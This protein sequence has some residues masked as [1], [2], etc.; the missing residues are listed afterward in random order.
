MEIAETVLS[1]VKEREKVREEKRLEKLE[2]LFFE[3]LKENFTENL[4]HCVEIPYDN[5]EIRFKNHSKYNRLDLMKICEMNGIKIISSDKFSYNGRATISIPEAVGNEKT[6][7]QAL[8]EK[9]N[10]EIMAEKEIN[11]NL[12]K[13]L[14]Q[15][16]FEKLKQG[17][18]DY[19]PDLFGKYQ[20]SLKTDILLSKKSDFVSKRVEEIFEEHG[21][22]NFF[23]DK[24]D[25]TI[26]HFI[27]QETKL[28]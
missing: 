13:D 24:H 14:C 8:M 9:Y 27:V 1:I 2:K 23:C 18:F 25:E 11:N 7:A 5:I 21:F 20:I 26:W 17:D 10:Q 15:K 16:A 4:E 6:V 19:N 12:A 28:L 3:E 22:Y